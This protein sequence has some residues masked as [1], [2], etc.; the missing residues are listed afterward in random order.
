MAVP[1]KGIDYGAPAQAQAG[2]A[3]NQAATISAA[4][5]AMARAQKNRTKRRKA[6][7]PQVVNSGPQPTTPAAPSQKK[8]TPLWDAARA[9]AQVEYG[10]P[11]RDLQSQIADSASRQANISGWY[12]TYL[13]RLQAARDASAQAYQAAGAPGSGVVTGAAPAGSSAEAQQAFANQQ[14]L[15]QAFNNMVRAQGANNTTMYDDMGANAGLSEIGW[16]Q[17][18]Q[19]NTDK[20]RDQ[21]RGLLQDRG[22]AVATKRQELKQQRFDNNLATRHQ[23]AEE[24]AV[25]AGIEA[26]RLADQEKSRQERL[27]DRRKTITSGPFAGLTNGEL[28]G[29]SQSERAAYKKANKDKKPGKVI[30][31]GAFAGYTE[32][33]VRAM[34]QATKDRLVRENRKGKGGGVTDKESRSNNNY[35]Q[36]GRA[37]TEGLGK[38]VA[39]TNPNAPTILSNEL[40]IPFD[41]AKI[42]IDRKRSGKLTP[43]QAKALDKLGIKYNQSLVGRA[44]GTSSGGGGGPHGNGTP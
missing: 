26:D 20:L 1:A 21:L 9:Y 31:S 14:Q 11:I 41:L 22:A 35:W 39:D 4:R 42:L 34:P 27:K 24:Y 40:N 30:T 19:R 10:E 17:D 16:H 6:S 18:E 43:A 3:A 36:K 23:A 12:Q 8:P 7:G 2:F 44:P 5:E 29:M 28:R 13:T 38:S 37:W 32:A 25:G 33:Q 15:S